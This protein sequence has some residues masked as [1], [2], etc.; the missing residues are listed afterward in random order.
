M[1]KIFNLSISFLPLALLFILSVKGQSNLI[2]NKG[3]N[4]QTL[5]EI[6]ELEP[7]FKKRNLLN[8]KIQTN[9]CFTF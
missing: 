5:T 8:F 7:D 6:W 4:F 1:I 3:N 9:L 2:F